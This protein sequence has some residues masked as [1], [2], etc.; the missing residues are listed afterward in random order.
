VELVLVVL[1]IVIPPV[2]VEMVKVAAVVGVNLE[3]P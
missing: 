2:S 1:N 3:N